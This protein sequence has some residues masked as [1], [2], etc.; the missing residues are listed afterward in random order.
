[1]RPPRPG[2]HASRAS[3]PKLAI[4]LGPLLIFFA[5]N[6]LAGIYA[7]TA[8]FM[9]ATLIS[10]DRGAYPLSQAAGDAAGQRRH[11]ARVRR[12]HA[13]SP[14]RDLHQAEADHRLYAV[15]GAAGGRAAVQKAGAR[16]AVRAG[17]QPHRRGM[18]QAHVCAGRPSS[19]PWPSSTSWSGAIS[20]PMP[21]SASRRSASCRSPSCSRSRRCR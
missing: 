3:V 17:V 7:G 11:R 1:M 4:E 10:L 12:A 21:G 15:R 8:A 5:G 2:G 16:A 20:R 13:L 18:A 6:A 19:S 9:V 14:R